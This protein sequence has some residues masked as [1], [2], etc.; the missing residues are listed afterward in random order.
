MPY[1]EQEW[2]LEG[3]VLL[4]GQILVQD[5]EGDDLSDA[6]ASPRVAVS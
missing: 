2:L 3:L 1:L 5:L 6:Q 4:K